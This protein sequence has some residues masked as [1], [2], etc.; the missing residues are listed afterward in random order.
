MRGAGFPGVI[1]H[2]ADHFL[3]LDACCVE[4]GVVQT[5]VGDERHSPG[6]YDAG[7]PSGHGEVP[8]GED[9]FG[10]MVKCHPDTQKRRIPMVYPGMVAAARAEHHRPETYRK[11]KRA[12]HEPF[13]RYPLL[14][15]E[16][17]AQGVVIIQSEL[18]RI[19]ESDAELGKGPGLGAAG[20]DQ[21]EKPQCDLRNRCA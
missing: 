12:R 11:W 3:A 1:R 17:G 8:K 14:A 4:L 20:W 5:A 18:K 6:D 16:I 19:L 10:R 9:A 15:D 2:H 7:E 21:S 13:Y